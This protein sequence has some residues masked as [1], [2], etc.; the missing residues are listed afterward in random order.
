MQLPLGEFASSLFFKLTTYLIIPTLFIVYWISQIYGHEKPFP[1]CWISKCAQHYPE[2][3]FF[4]VATISGSV[5]MMLGWFT[6]HFYLKS[7]CKE[8]AFNLRQYYPEIS[9]VLGLMGGMLLMGSTASI[10]TGKM[11]TH[12]HTF[13]A[14]NFFIFTLAAQ[15]YNAIVYTFVY[16]NTKAVSYKN[17]LVKYVQ[18]GLLGIQAIV[19]LYQSGVGGFWNITEENQSSANQ[20]DIFLEWTLTLTVIMGFYSMS[21]DVEKFA[22]VYES[23]QLARKSGSEQ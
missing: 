7:V 18:I 5:P 8:Q 11:N 20:L 2:F 1:N 19:S 15:V 12:L 9:L 22:F 3:V 17:L 16:K 10:D 13:C 4:R 23:S 6:N 21:L 14:S